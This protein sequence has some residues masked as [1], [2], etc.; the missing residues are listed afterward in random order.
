M[1]TAIPNINISRMVIDIFGDDEVNWENNDYVLFSEAF[2]RYHKS[3]KA[4][5]KRVISGQEEN[6]IRTCRRRSRKE[7]YVIQL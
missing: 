5:E 1:T 6:H 2:K 4:R 7:R 3:C